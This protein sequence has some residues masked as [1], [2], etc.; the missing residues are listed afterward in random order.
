MGGRGLCS[1]KKNLPPVQKVP[2]VYRVCQIA[3]T[4]LQKC[5]K[6]ELLWNRT[7]DKVTSSKNTRLSGLSTCLASFCLSYSALIV[8]ELWP[9]L[10]VICLKFQRWRSE[11]VFFLFFFRPFQ[12]WHPLLYWFSCFIWLAHWI[13]AQTCSSAHSECMSELRVQSEKSRAGTN[14]KSSALK[15]SEWK[16]AT[17]Y[18]REV[19]P[20]KHRAPALQ[21]NGEMVLYWGWGLLIIDTFL[22]P[23]CVSGT[24][25]WSC[26]SGSLQWISDQIDYQLVLMCRGFFFFISKLG[27]DLK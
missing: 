4:G 23:K 25:S 14:G 22:I 8:A 15:K 19:K 21:L 11:K 20:P 6:T 26:Q 5:C 24:D 2:P 13:H 10:I 27:S 3:K 9:N 18:S 16:L 7:T 17:G 1:K 12:P